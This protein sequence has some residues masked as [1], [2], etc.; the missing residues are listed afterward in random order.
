[1]T[2]AKHFKLLRIILFFLLFTI[3][4][5]CEELDSLLINCADC[6]S[7]EPL[8]ASLKIE[9]NPGDGNVTINVFEGRLEDSLLYDSRTTTALKAEIS[10]PVNKSYTL[11]AEYSKSGKHYFTINSVTPHAIYD[12][13]HCDVPC[14]I[15]KDVDVDLRLKYT[16]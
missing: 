4:F 15:L 9:I 6:R 12:K 14:Y 16:K 1:M 3:F 2:P 5:S 7:E 11:T 8:N 13:D 10:V